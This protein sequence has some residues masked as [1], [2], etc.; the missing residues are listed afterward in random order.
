MR[1]KMDTFLW[2]ISHFSCRITVVLLS[3]L[4]FLGLSWLHQSGGL[5]A[6]VKTHIPLIITIGIIMLL[7]SITFAVIGGKAGYEYVDME[8]SRRWLYRSTAFSRGDNTFMNVL[9]WACKF[10]LIPIIIALLALLIYIIVDL[11]HYC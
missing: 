10:A 6:L 1:N 5:K 2:L 3:V 8:R 9:Y 7:F 4:D 11:V